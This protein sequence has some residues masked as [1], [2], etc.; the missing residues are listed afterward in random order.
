MEEWYTLHTKPNAEFQVATALQRQGL[1]VYLPAIETPAGAR[2]RRRE[3]FFPCYLF[4]KIDFELMSLS[5]VQ[6][7]PGLR[8]V[9]T[10]GDRPAPVPNEIIEL[11]QIRLGAIRANGDRPAH[12]F[13]PGDTVRIINGPF[14]DMLAI[15]EGP[16]TP[17]RRVQVLLSILGRTSRVHVELASLKKVW[18]RIEPN[19][20]R[21]RRT[22]GRGRR[23]YSP[24]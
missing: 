12:A 1:K 21:P 15:F 17:S 18:D 14:R 5:Q 19:I 7:T 16:T 24:S 2:G 11:I 20:S 22:R 6:W 13:Q 10:S 8:R 9:L 4:L 3:P 23:I